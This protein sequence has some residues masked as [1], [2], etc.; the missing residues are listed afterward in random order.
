MSYTTNYVF[1]V[2]IEAEKAIAEAKKIG[3]TL[4]AAL[5]TGLAS[6]KELNRLENQIKR[7]KT[8]VNRLVKESKDEAVSGASDIGEA[9]E[10][11]IS[12]ALARVQGMGFNL[13]YG[14]Y[15]A[16]Y[17]AGT[18]MGEGIG[19][20]I[21]YYLTS[22]L[23]QIA[24]LLTSGISTPLLEAGGNITGTTYG[25][26]EVWTMV[27]AIDE[28][29]ST[30]KDQISISQ[31][32]QAAW[33][34]L[35]G[36][37]GQFP[38]ILSAFTQGVTDSTKQVWALRRALYGLETLG[39]SIK[40]TGLT[41]VSYIENAVTAYGDFNEAITRAAMAM[42]MSIDL[43][44]EF[45][46]AVLGVASA[47]GAFEADE[48]AEGMR[49]WAAGTGAV[50]DEYSDLNEVLNSSVAVQKLAAMNNVGLEATIDQ[51]GSA[52]K[53]FGLNTS[54]TI[55]VV[56]A[57]NYVAAK[58]FANVDDLGQALKMVGPIVESLGVS[59]NEVV[60]ALG[61][62]SD[63]NIKGTMAGRALRQT[64]IRLS[65]TTTDANRVLNQLT[66]TSNN[67]SDAWRDIV[68]P[69][70]QFMGLAE[71]IDLLAAGMEDMT[72]AQRN[73]AIA[74][75][76]T[77][78][79]QS[80]LT[81]LIEQQIEA[82]QYGV[83]VLS[84]EQKLMEGIT[85]TET[86]AYL[87][88]KQD[89]GENLDSTTS[90]LSLWEQMWSRFED[91]TQVRLQK[92]AN[93]WDEF[94]IGMGDILADQ[95]IPV[96]EQGL[97]LLDKLQDLIEANPEI[98][99]FAGGAAV[100]TVGGGALLETV[101][102][103]GKNVANLYTIFA[104][105]K[106]A[107]AFTSTIAAGGTAT[108]GVAASATTLAGLGS[109]AGAIASTMLPILGAVLVA[110]GAAW[111]FSDLRKAH[112]EEA[113]STNEQ[114]I[115]SQ[116]EDLQSLFNKLFRKEL[117][118]G[119]G[120]VARGGEYE[121]QADAILDAIYGS[122]GFLNIKRNLRSEDLAAAFALLA[123][124]ANA[125]AS[126]LAGISG[127]R[128]TQT[129]TSSSASTSSL[130]D[131]YDM[132]EDEIAMVEAYKDM[133]DAIEAADRQFNED[134]S[135]AGD[136]WQEAKAEARDDYIES[137]LDA[138]KEYAKEEK[139]AQEDLYQDLEDLQRDY[140]D[141]LQ[142][143]EAD[144]QQ[145][146][147]R[148]TEDFYTELQRMERD[149]QYNMIDLI[150][151]RDVEAISKEMRDYRAN[152]ADYTADFST[153]MSREAQDYQ[154]QQDDLTSSYEE[155]LA[156]R[157]AAYEEDAANRKA[158][159]EEDLADYRETFDEAVAFADTAYKE[160]MALAQEN[161][162]ESVSSAEDA[163][164]EIL[165]EYTGL[166]DSIR[167]ETYPQMLADLDAFMDDWSATYIERMGLAGADG[168]DAFLESSMLED[169]TKA[170]TQGQEYASKY[171]VNPEDLAGDYSNQIT[172][173]SALDTI[174]V[175]P[176]TNQ[177]TSVTIIDQS[178][179]SGMTSEDIEKY[180]SISKE[181]LEKLSSRVA[182]VVRK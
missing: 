111:L 123:K 22:G 66:E 173:P 155:G 38:G 64:F 31:Q 164:G 154:Q 168:L 81:A 3:E 73:Y 9:I 83:N 80:A 157:W 23:P 18:Q 29:T 56:A 32:L 44:D 126:N 82:R 114:V 69:E 91:S 40:Q 113:L 120:Y 71:Y 176:L 79:E 57:L 182:Q 26:D 101:A 119:S 7:L 174:S 132:T 63:A 50:V 116:A 15:E 179:Y 181:Q 25:P 133:L 146:V 85:D 39:R 52:M 117:F 108:A 104:G 68:F 129:A 131:Y 41:W 165:A 103:I 49:L 93:R 55:D 58:S 34:S 160:A 5:D 158:S 78:N 122:A 17:N 166:A 172:I 134:M 141:S 20:A 10:T 127:A 35:R 11:E 77:A 53:T 115:E 24:G 96:L 98:I 95:F 60:T 170:I 171:S 1:Q 74:T 88:M 178:T 12:N 110:V 175:A 47:T 143:N 94:V 27:D 142:E 70:G 128:L 86:E 135:S 2:D 65:E 13:G 167:E 59:F 30:E 151:S 109:S 100:V 149:H 72:A 99:K 97:D 125:A 162:D 140:L 4:G 144:Y 150:E 107:S 161:H 106:M 147:A 21:V 130:V 76:T 43:E 92:I 28:L 33:G 156:D 6:T 54:D 90:A 137:T 84:A 163:A 148:D 8:V 145:Q 48:L 124:S 16:G 89:M 75:L 67:T 14:W 138:E 62:L 105:F 42:E 46:D 153:S 139:A 61:L 36:V 118:G 102:D 121:D 169:L 19:E 51:V 45:E 112:N 159:L 180:R 136:D 87:Q 37:A 177:T 152:V